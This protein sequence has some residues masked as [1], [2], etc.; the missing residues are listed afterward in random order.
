MDEI[1]LPKE[2]I[3]AIMQERDALKARVTELEREVTSEDWDPAP[4]NWAD[5]PI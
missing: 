5:I 2:Q 4:P 3:A 1:K